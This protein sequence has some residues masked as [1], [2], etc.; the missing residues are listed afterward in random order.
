VLGRKTS[1]AYRKPASSWITGLNDFAHK[2]PV[3]R[4]VGGMNLIH[5]PKFNWQDIETILPTLPRFRMVS[6]KKLGLDE[7][8]D[9]QVI[10]REAVAPHEA[11]ALSAI[12]TSKYKM[13]QHGEVLCRAVD[14]VGRHLGVEKPKI[15][16]LV[17][18]HGRQAEFHLALATVGNFAP[19]GFPIQLN[20]VCSN[21]VDG[22]H[23]FR[24][25]LR[26]LRLVC[27]NGMMAG[28]SLSSRKAHRRGLGLGSA[29][30]AIAEQIDQCQQDAEG[31]S[32]WVDHPVS[33]NVIAALADGVVARR[34]G[35]AA[36]TRFWHI[37]QTGCDVRT[38]PPYNGEKPTE[39]NVRYIGAVPG[40]P[41]QAANIFD[42]AQALSWIA[43]RERDL[44]SVA[45]RQAEIGHMLRSFPS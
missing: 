33:M 39:Q 45:S 12:V 11:P 7:C 21:S 16:A 34:W 19:D 27:S 15:H 14:W 5:L 37:C 43:S 13:L 44:N 18:D 30:A 22:R 42:A 23:S 35:S 6:P 29:L 32:R 8:G 31:M 28:V 1:A 20:M 3:R 10:V 17:M 24:V 36:A 9:Q 40:A 38:I 26:W 41:K 25:G 4:V 2:M